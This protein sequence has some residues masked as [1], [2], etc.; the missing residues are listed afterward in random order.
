M[1]RNEVLELGGREFAPD[2]VISISQILLLRDG[3]LM[4]TADGGAAKV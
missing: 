1:R 3:S 2:D 4:G